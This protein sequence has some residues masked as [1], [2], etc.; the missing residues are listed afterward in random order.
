MEVAP[1]LHL[2]PIGHV[3]VFVLETAEGV[4]VIDAGLPGSEG[5]ILD[6]LDAID[7]A[8][9]GVGHIVVTH[10]HPDH[11]GGLAALVE[12]TAAK[13]WM[14]AADGAL[15]AQGRAARPMSPAP[16]ARNAAL[17]RGMDIDTRIPPARIDHVLVDGDRLPFAPVRVLHTPG[18]SAG[19]LALAVDLAGGDVLLVA[20]AA[21]NMDD[22]LDLS[23]AYEDIDEGRRSLARLAGSETVAAVT[24][25]FG[26]GPPVA[27]ETFRARFGSLQL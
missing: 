25:C 1:G 15:V 17:F 2:V 10:L 16:G 24:V 18:H 3:N 23:V 14:H 8:P 22:D 4:V 11:A 20:D 19:H 27:A 6:A 7:V 12:A 21:S 13:T 26:H 5:T 9:G